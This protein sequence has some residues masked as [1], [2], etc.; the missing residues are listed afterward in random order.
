MAGGRRIFKMILKSWT[1]DGRAIEPALPPGIGENARE[2]GKGEG[3]K[4][5]NFSLRY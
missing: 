4:T 5:R 1:H 2:K 3:D